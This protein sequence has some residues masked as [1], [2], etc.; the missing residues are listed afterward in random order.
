MALPVGLDGDAAAAQDTD[1]GPGFGTADS[2]QQIDLVL[3]Q[4]HVA[5]VKPLTL[6]DLVE[7]EEQQNGVGLFGQLDGLGLQSGVRFAVTGRS[8]WQ[9]RR[10]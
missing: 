10:S 5:A 1:A 6:L 3:G 7:A 2:Q 9:N 4:L 8:P